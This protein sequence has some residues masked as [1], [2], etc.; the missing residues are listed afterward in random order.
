MK[1]VVNSGKSVRRPGKSEIAFVEISTG[2]PIAKANLYSI[3]LY[4]KTKK[5]NRKCK[6]IVENH[7]QSLNRLLIYFFDNQNLV[8]S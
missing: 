6:Y 3:D 8:A 2:L 4:R 1:S 7:M 5:K